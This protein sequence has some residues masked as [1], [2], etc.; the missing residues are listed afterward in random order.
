MNRLNE[1]KANAPAIELMTPIDD[2][3]TP[4]SGIPTLTP[5]IYLRF[6]QSILLLGTSGNLQQFYRDIE[7]I[8]KHIDLI[9]TATTKIANLNYIAI[10]ATT[11]QQ[12]E[13]AAAE[14]QPT[15]AATNKK[16]AYTKQ[17]IQRLNDENK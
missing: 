1:L 17:F 4:A 9:K 5:I 7:I 15:L 8:K 14:L 12:E 16:A 3:Q 2:D 11:K 10:Q 6:Y 13:S